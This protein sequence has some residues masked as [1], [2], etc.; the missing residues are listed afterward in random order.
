MEFFF[1]QNLAYYK[2]IDAL[3][4]KMFFVASKNYFIYMMVKIIKF[5][6]VGYYKFRM[7]LLTNEAL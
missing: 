6:S 3:V 4:S 2:Y 7:R 1:F 5:D